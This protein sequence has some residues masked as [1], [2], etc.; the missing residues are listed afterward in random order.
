MNNKLSP[1]LLSVVSQIEEKDIENLIGALKEQQVK[2]R[3]L[4]IKKAA[5]A[6][7]SPRDTCTEHCCL[8]HGCKYSKRKCSVVT[9]KK[10]QSY[11]CEYCGHGTWPPV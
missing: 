2:L 4:R 9:G 6:D 8:E 1:E 10:A 11:P 5:D 7:T 3:F